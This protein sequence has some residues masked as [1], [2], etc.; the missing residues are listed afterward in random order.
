MLSISAQISTNRW[1][2]AGGGQNTPLRLRIRAAGRS[3]AISGRHETRK[4]HEEFISILARPC[5]PCRQL[6][7]HVRRRRPADFGRAGVIPNPL[8]NNFRT[9]PPNGVFQYGIY[10][11]MPR[12]LDLMDKRHVKLS[13]FMI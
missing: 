6:L 12:L 2:K 10:E 5:S 4:H 8:R 11:G 7:A 13:G 1:S 3:P 9:C